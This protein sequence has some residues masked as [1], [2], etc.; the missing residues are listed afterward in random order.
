MIDAAH[1][2]A[3]HR[4]SH[5]SPLP[6]WVPLV[7]PPNPSW[8]IQ[9]RG[10]AQ[11]STLKVDRGRLLA[12][13]I[14]PI[15]EAPPERLRPGHLRVQ[16]I[17]EQGEDGQGGGG[18]TRAF[19]TQAG[20]LVSRWRLGLFLP[21]PGGRVQLSALPGLLVTPGA[22]AELE[23]GGSGSVW[24]QPE[25]WARLLGRLLGMAVVHEC[26]FG[27]LLVPSLCKQLVGLEPSFD[28]LQ[29]APGL[30]SSSGGDPS[31]SGGAAAS[32]FTSLRAL[33]QPLEA[34]A[35][36]AHRIPSTDEDGHPSSTS[37]QEVDEAL[38]GL[39]AVVPSRAAQAYDAL[40]G[41]IAE[42]GPAPQGV[43]PTAAAAQ[44][45]EE[46]ADLAQQLLCTAR[47]SQQMRVARGAATDLLAAANGGM[48]VMPAG[49]K[50]SLLELQAALRA[51][52]EVTRAAV[53]R[54]RGI[55]PGGRSCAGREDVA[56]LGSKLEEDPP[57]L[58]RDMSVVS[59]DGLA[60]GEALS[61]AT[62]PAFTEA[63]TRKALTENL[64]PHLRSLVSEFRLVVSPGLLEALTWQQV[65]ERIAGQ[66]LD[67]E[68]FVD[69]WQARTTYHACHFLH[70]T[71][72]LWWSFVREA[73][74]EASRSL[75]EWCTSYAAMPA[76]AW[77][78]QIRLLESTERCPSVNLCMTDATDAA[79]HGVKMPTLYLP[80][81]SSMAVLR[82]KMEWAL[83]GP[84]GGP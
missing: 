6:H 11:K 42:I 24:L 61:A 33:M 20:A 35:E 44:Q 64:Q 71:V 21:A 54:P 9:A 75:F 57:A 67:K 48:D 62:L 50:R 10:S 77:R 19:L 69:E 12:S 83:A 8:E 7:R 14:G 34:E 28:D 31:C 84:P 49:A 43:A 26:P 70:P 55:C 76:T 5:G 74:P 46:F 22:P 73:S 81:Y 60:A 2:A 32:W 79:N 4:G 23:G 80:A 39:C 27:V 38:S 25:R 68:A 53:Q 72:R 29:F 82:R 37:S 13:V 56:K 1:Q 16:Y 63:L 40:A 30:G 15:L 65:Q 59:L 78:F 36:Q 45:F 58:V 66:L 41:L 52:L 17:G 47:T 51:E 3:S 18:V